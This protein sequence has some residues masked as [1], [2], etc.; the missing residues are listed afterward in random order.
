MRESGWG[1]GGE[2]VKVSFW[3]RVG[4]IFLYILLG[5]ESGVRWGGSLRVK[6]GNVFGFFF[7]FFMKE[8]LMK[9][10]YF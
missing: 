10:F 3:V 4:V 7:V 5:I 1:W 2:W 9:D 6:G 8:N